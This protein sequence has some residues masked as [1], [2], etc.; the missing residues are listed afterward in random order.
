MEDKIRVSYTW[1]I[2]SYVP[3][4]EY[5]TPIFKLGLNE[6]QVRLF[7]TDDG[8]YIGFSLSNKS[9]KD[10]TVSYTLTL[11]N[12]FKL[13]DFVYQDPDDRVTFTSAGDADDQWGCEDLISKE[14]LQKTR[15][16]LV[17]GPRAQYKLKVQLDMIIYGCGD[18]TGNMMDTALLNLI[19]NEVADVDDLIAYVDDSMDE[20]MQSVSENVASKYNSTSKA[21]TMLNSSSAANIGFISKDNIALKYKQDRLVNNRLAD[22][23]Y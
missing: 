1:N 19:N 9:R 7:P 4:K 5:I 20:I 8:E 14:E 16:L 3:H 18:G 23:N 15:G 6:W 22:S 17:K 21:E 12:Q 2:D 10:V 11:K 13:D